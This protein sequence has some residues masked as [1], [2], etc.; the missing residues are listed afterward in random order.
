M[1]IRIEDGPEFLV[2]GGPAGETLHL[3]LEHARYWARE[4]RRRVDDEAV[5]RREIALRCAGGRCALPGQLR[6]P[7]ENTD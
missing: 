2:P 1:K 7:G 3:T 5:R 6:L 4:L